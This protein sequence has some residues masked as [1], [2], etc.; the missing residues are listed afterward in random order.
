MFQTKTVEKIKRHILCWRTIFRTSC[1]LRD[2]GRK[3]GTDRQADGDNIIRKMHVAR[4]VDKARN[5]HWE[6]VILIA[7]LRQQCYREHAS[8]LRYV[9]LPA[10]LASSF[11]VATS[12]RIFT[13]ILPTVSNT[14]KKHC[15]T[16]LCIKE[17]S[18]PRSCHN[19]YRI[20]HHC[21]KLRLVLS[22]LEYHF[23]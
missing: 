12:P 6:Y 1:S 7:F 23:L 9:T 3:Y 20:T 15:K 13:A 2:N 14:F 11:Y 8:V 5:T 10:L 21:S 4:W 19:A 16:K 22:K 17:E 18:K